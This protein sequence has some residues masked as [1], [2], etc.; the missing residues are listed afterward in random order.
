MVAVESRRARSPRPTG[1]ARPAP[2]PSTPPRGWDRRAIR[3]WALVGLA[4]DLLFTGGWLLAGRVAGNGY[5][6]LRDD[7]SDLGAV[8]APHAWVLLVPQFLAGLAAI[9][10]ALWALRPMLAAAGR[11]GVTGPWL[12]ALS[13][14]QDLSDAVFRPDCR[15]ADGCGQ[16]QATASWH[17]QMHA[18]VGLVCAV[19][20][21]AT[22][23]ILAR[24]MRR[25]SAWRD[26]ATP[27][28][29][30]GLL[31]IVGIVGVGAPQTAGVHGLIQRGMALL[32]V[33]WDVVLIRRIYR[34]TAA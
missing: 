22:P 32:G 28:L 23:F 21:C 1:A 17:G 33:L 9:A 20:F 24:R 7:I 3:R 11:A 10:S 29:L 15:A 14:V 26:L 27:S 18:I 2:A 13:A 5:S 30:L 19:L 25:L 16:A 31:L 8:T 6:V 34:L 12:A 4:G